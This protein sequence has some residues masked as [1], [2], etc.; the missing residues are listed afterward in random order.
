MLPAQDLRLKMPIILSRNIAGIGLS[1][2]LDML[3][4][5]E[6]DDDGIEWVYSIHCTEPGKRGA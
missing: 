3:V 6:I 2:D 1:T 4:I 5:G